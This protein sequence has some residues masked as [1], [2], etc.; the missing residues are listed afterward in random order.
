MEGRDNRGSS[1]AMVMVFLSVVSVLSIATSVQSSGVRRLQS[2]SQLGF[3]AVELCDSAINEASQ[4]LEWTHIFPSSR[5]GAAGLR[6][7]FQLVSDDEDAGQSK[8]AA[9]F[10]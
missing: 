2:R 6:N 1:L 4:Q 10:P 8:L 9:A 3:E 5:F 7:L